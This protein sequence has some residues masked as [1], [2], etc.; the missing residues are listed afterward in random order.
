M[1]GLPYGLAAAIAAATLII[2]CVTA[3]TTAEENDKKDDDP[4]A[5][6]KIITAHIMQPP[7][8]FT[9]HTMCS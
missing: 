3:I 1:T 8:V 4:I 5:T 2:A 9:L 7:F 6:A